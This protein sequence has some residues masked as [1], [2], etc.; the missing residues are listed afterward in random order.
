MRFDTSQ[1]NQQLLTGKGI[2]TFKQAVNG[3]LFWL[4]HLFQRLLP[5][6]GELKLL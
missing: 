6:V 3:G 4:L 1:G 2:Q 5:G